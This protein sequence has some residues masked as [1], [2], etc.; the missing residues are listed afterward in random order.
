MTPSG[1]TPLNY[2]L[3]SSC[4]TKLSDPISTWRYIL[5][6]PE[7]IDDFSPGGEPFLYYAGFSMNGSQWLYQQSA[8]LLR[9]EDACLIR[10]SV[11]W[12]T[13]KF[14]CMAPYWQL[15]LLDYP[16]FDLDEKTLNA[17]RRGTIPLLSSMFFYCEDPDC[18]FSLGDI[19]LAW[20][21]NSGLD[22][23]DMISQ[24]VD[25]A[26]IPDRVSEPHKRFV[27]EPRKEGGWRLGFEYA[28]DREASGYLLLSVFG[29]LMVGIVWSQDWPIYDSKTWGDPGFFEWIE[30]QKTRFERRMA[31]RARKESGQK[32]CKRKMPG[33]WVH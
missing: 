9:L 20:L 10:A 23:E 1:F 19:F 12:E 29:T 17:M 13:W 2:A 16:S 28:F 31:A 26:N 3:A 22:L 6:D 18:S 8:N 30:K 4:E 7:L 33:A 32:R 27:Y 14:L 15:P 24:E 11:V 21:S 5:E 25:L